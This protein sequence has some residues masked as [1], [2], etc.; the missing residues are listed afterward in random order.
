MRVTRSIRSTPHSGVVSGRLRPARA[1]RAAIPR[2]NDGDGAAD[3]PGDA[4]CADAVADRENPECDDG[5]DNNGD[6]A[7]DFPADAGCTAA[8]SEE[9]G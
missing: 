9:E 3:F 5:I 4:G 7:A 6:G 1:S 8:S 2:T